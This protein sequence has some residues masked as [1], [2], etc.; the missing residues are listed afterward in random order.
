MPGGAPT[1]KAAA[2]RDNRISH[3]GHYRPRDDYDTHNIIYKIPGPM[4]ITSHVL[5]DAE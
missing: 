5:W 3:F 4:Q 1:C 2:Q